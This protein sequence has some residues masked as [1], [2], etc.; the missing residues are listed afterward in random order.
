VPA[1]PVVLTLLLLLL[2]LAPVAQDSTK[3]KNPLIRALAIRTMGC[4]RVEQITEYLCQPLQLCL[5]DEDPYVRKT[6][7]V[8]VAKLYDIS[9]SLVEAQ[10][11][12]ELLVDLLSDANP[13]VVSNAVAAL[14]EI[15]ETS[16]DAFRV[17]PHTLSKLLAALNECSEWGQIFILNA[18]AAYDPKDSREAEGI[19][20]RVT[21]RL[22]HNNSAVV[23]GAIRVLMKYLDAIRSAEAI[24][25]LTKKMGAPLG[26]CERCS[27]SFI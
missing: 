22:Q 27:H 4:I 25:T 11:F 19:A 16:P 1:R 14:S 12:L 13:M 15:A 6:A 3:N 17:T 24:R 20:E 26:T 23:L 21:A 10:G 8:C 7:A 9:P 5:K 18:L 2:L